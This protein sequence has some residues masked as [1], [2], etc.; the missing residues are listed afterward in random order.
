[1]SKLI[2]EDNLFIK[3]IWKQVESY[4]GFMEKLRPKESL[5]VVSE[6]GSICNKYTQDQEIWSKQLPDAVRYN[7]LG[8]LVNT[9]R[10]LTSL[11]T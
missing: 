5:L 3:E 9:I 6:I 4:V 8:I 11:K 1:M 10:L 7:K 2:S